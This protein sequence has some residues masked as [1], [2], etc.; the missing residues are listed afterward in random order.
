M[1]LAL[2]QATRPMLLE[3]QRLQYRLLV[4]RPRQHVLLLRRDA[5]GVGV[6]VEVGRE[7]LAMLPLQMSIIYSVCYFHGLKVNMDKGKTEAMVRLQGPGSVGIRRL[8]FG[9]DPLF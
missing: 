9:A 6:G 8:L 3:A 5:E 1:L 2:L 7:V 4:W